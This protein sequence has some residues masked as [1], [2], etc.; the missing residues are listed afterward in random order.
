MI[1]WNWPQNVKRGTLRTVIG[2]WDLDMARAVSGLS[3]RRPS[4]NSIPIYVG[5]VVDRVALARVCL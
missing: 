2:R 3:L 1:Y 4:F 5:L